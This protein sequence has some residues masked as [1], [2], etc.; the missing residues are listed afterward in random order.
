MPPPP[1]SVLIPA[2]IFFTL[3][4]ILLVL[5][6]PDLHSLVPN[7]VYPRQPVTITCTTR[8]SQTLAWESEEYIGGGTQLLLTSSHS[9][10]S[11]NTSRNGAIGI[12]ISVT[13]DNGELMIESELLINIT[14]RSSSSH[15][16]CRN[17][18]SGETDTVVFYK[19]NESATELL[20]TNATKICPEDSISVACTARN[21]SLIKWSSNLHNRPLYCENNDPAVRNITINSGDINIFTD[22]LA[23]SASG[24]SVLTCS[25]TIMASELP[26]DQQISLECLNVDIGVPQASTITFQITGTCACV[27]VC[28]C[29]CVPVSGVFA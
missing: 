22:Y 24:D 15:V 9:P 12:L 23:T 26:V 2:N 13:N 17:V 8:N 10:Y 4:V 1:S 11:T 27:C 19:T 16:T 7:P 28:V 21:T 25:L 5:S 6:A 14:T 18:N 3:L 29:V 20:L